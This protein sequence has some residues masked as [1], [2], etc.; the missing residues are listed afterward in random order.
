MNSDLLNELGDQS[1]PSRLVAGADAGTRIAVEV[2]VEWDQ[3][4]PVRIG[5]KCFDIAEHGTTGFVVVEKESREPH[6]D[7]LGD[8]PERHHAA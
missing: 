4:V 2:F 1:R 6:R 3:V 5:L 7:F 8:L